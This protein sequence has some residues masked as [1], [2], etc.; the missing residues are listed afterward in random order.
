MHP[1]EV[2]GVCSIKAVGPIS[3]KDG[4]DLGK[5]KSDNNSSEG[6]GRGIW[7]CEY[8]DSTLDSLLHLKPVRLSNLSVDEKSECQSKGEEA[9]LGLISI[10]MIQYPKIYEGFE[11]SVYSGLSNVYDDLIE[12]GEI[13]KDILE[14]ETD[15]KYIKSYNL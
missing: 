1:T 2:R 4:I 10:Q 13:N 6:F 7:K 12:K 15:G 5:R 9:W 14:C 3:H 8:V 11:K